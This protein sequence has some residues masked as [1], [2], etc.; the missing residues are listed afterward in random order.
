[1]FKINL[2]LPKLFYEFQLKKDFNNRTFAYCILVIEQK[3]ILK[4]TALYFF[5][6]VE[7]SQLKYEYFTVAITN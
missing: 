7:S 1:M 6:T 3:N 5:L 4:S 2:P